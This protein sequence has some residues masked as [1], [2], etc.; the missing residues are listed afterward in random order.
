MTA[1]PPV[2]GPRLVLLPLC[3][4]IIAVYARM[5]DLKDISTDEGFR[6]WIIH[7]GQ[8]LVR[9]EPAADASWARVIEANRPYAYQP[10]YFLIQNSLMRVL[11]A[12]GLNFFRSVNL[13]FLGLG[14][15]GLLVLSRTWRLAPRLFLLVVFSFNAFLF[16]HVL[17]I[18]EYIAGVAFYVWSTWVVLELDRRE[19][20]RP[21]ADAAWFAGYGVLL[22]AGFYLQSWVV[23]PAIGQGLFLL[24]RR[25]AR[26]GRFLALLALAYGIVLATTAPYLLGHQQKVNVGLWASDHEPLEA[27][28]SQGFHLLFAGHLPGHSRF[29]DFLFWFWPVMLAGG[30]FLFVWDRTSLRAPAMAVE[31]RR[32][33][34]LMVLCIM[35][36]LAFQVGYTL[37]IE[38]LAVWPRYF[39]IHYFFLVW[40]I[41]LS[42]RYMWELRTTAAGWTRH[43][44]TM[45]AAILG[46]VLAASAAY[47]VRSFRAD[48]YLDTGQNS[49]ANWHNVA[50]SLARHLRPGDVVMTSDFINRATLTFTRPIAHEVIVL[51]E[52]ER[53]EPTPTSRLVYLEPAGLRAGR[54]ELVSRLLARGYSAPEE[55][56]V[57]GTDGVGITRD[58]SI[59]IFSR[60]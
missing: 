56:P 17:Q 46:A 51:A 30:A 40:L 45:V 31:S 57:R 7:G 15:L 53:H 27:H 23:F 41:A 13:A 29:T 55:S 3:L 24:L 25:R 22:T 60:R 28:L 36:S 48:P 18:R 49:V 44:L 20:D 4:V 58:W 34:L 35:V 38:N 43:G 37:L 16:M 54:D 52:L 26:W 33:G 12:E 21:R 42:F 50:V 8:S 1:R 47:Q 32:Q 19:L 5:M 59:L 39:V 2:F 6:L 11:H 14:L 9:G 10:L